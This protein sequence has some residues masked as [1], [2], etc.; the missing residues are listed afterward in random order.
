MAI[1]MNSK[2]GLNFE[3]N[4]ELYS[5]K[6]FL[7]G[8]ISRTTVYDQFVP[9]M[10]I[11]GFNGMITIRLVIH[12]QLDVWEELLRVGESTRDIIILFPVQMFLIDGAFLV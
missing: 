7:R 3:N 6:E 12:I 10:R 9:H 1:E 2:L 8:H 5:N 11:S 4:F